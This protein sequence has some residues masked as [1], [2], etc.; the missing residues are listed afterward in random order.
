MNTSFDRVSD[1]TDVWLT[2]PDLLRAL[3]EF[4]L[5]PC[6][7]IN[8][9]WEMAKKHYTETDNGLMQ[10]W[11]GRVWCNPPYGNEAKH[12]LNKCAMHK[13]AMAL[14]FARTETQMFFESVWPVAH[15]MYFLK[16]RLSFYHVTGKK[17]GTAGAPSV[18]IAYDEQNSEVL[19]NL[20]VPG[21]FILLK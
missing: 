20:K 14:V 5:D 7:P 9:P 19:K 4:D 18:L 11:E 6:A 2:P 12:W 10:N 16:G 17:G 21:K 8:R 3:G 13:N 15:S 1:G